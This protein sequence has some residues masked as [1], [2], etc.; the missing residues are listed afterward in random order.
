MDN[1]RAEDEV[2]VVLMTCPDAALAQELGTALV[3]E[4]LA[5]CVNRVPGIESTYVWEGRVRTDAEILLLAKTTRARLAALT[6]R[7]HALHPYELPEIVA[8]PVCGGSERYLGWVRQS[9]RP[10]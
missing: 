3:A 1:A 7:V 8:L 2:L 5:A 4:N 9:I 6:M 10:V